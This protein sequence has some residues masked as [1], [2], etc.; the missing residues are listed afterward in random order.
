MLDARDRLT[1]LAEAVADGETPDWDTASEEAADDEERAAVRQLRAIADAC[2]M[3]AELAVHASSSMRSLLADERRADGTGVVDVPVVWGSLRIHDKIGRG[4]FGDVYR[5]WDPSLERE[6]ALKL[7]RHDHGATDRLVVDEGRLMARVRHPN[8]ATIYGALRINGRT[9]LWMELIEG[10]TLE[11]ELAVRGPF[12]AADLARIGIELCHALTAVHAAGLVHRD[13]KASN[14][15]QEAGGRIVLGDFG[16]GHELHETADATAMAGTPAYLAPEVFQN[17]PATPQRDVYSLGAL[18]FHLATGSY[19]IRGRTIGE[20]RE[21]HTLGT[22]MLLREARPDLP[23]PLAAT[24]DT[25]LEPD[26]A[27]RFPDAAS[28]EAALS[29]ALPKAPGQIGRQISS[30]RMLGFGATAAALVGGTLWLT[31]L[32]NAG[33]PRA[34]VPLAGGLEAARSF[35]QISPDSTLAGPGGPSP[36]GRLLS[37]RGPIRRPRDPRDRYRQALGAHGK[38]RLEDAHGIRGDVALHVG[39]CEGSVRLVSAHA[40]GVSRGRA[41]HR[42]AEHLDLWRRAA[43]PVERYRQQP[44]GLEA[45]VGGR[46]PDPRQRMAGGT[47]LPPRGR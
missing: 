9:G 8:V 21:A 45:L 47:A 44:V 19:P 36:D 29:R 7:L 14:V 23:E 22:R 32:G 40:D 17:A 12:P 35:R 25:A 33:R 10:Q 30:W 37:L 13:V 15:L 20:I 39:R 27:R 5:A 16:T 18:L 31:G 1:V 34:T 43:R 46:S 26:P 38:R 3:N 4:R 41:A 42:V 24:V 28:M 11:A 6:V 2:R